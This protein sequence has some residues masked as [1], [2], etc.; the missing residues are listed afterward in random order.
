MIFWITIWIGIRAMLFIARL[1]NLRQSV[2]QRAIFRET[3]GCLWLWPLPMTAKRRLRWPITV[4]A[5]PCS[6]ALEVHGASRHHGQSAARTQ[7]RSIRFGQLK[8]G[9]PCFLLSTLKPEFIRV[10]GNPLRRFYYESR[11]LHASGF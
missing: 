3:R 1:Q 9:T 6:V 4:E 10:S 8:A 5:E 2:R 11:R 7:R